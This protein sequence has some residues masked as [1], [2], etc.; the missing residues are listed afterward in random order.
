M[1]T[2]LKVRESLFSV[3]GL[4]VN[5]TLVFGVF[6]ALSCSLVLWLVVYSVNIS[7]C[8]VLFG[9]V[10]NILMKR[11]EEVNDVAAGTMMISLVPL[12]L[13]VFYTICWCFVFKLWRKVRH[14]DN[15][16]VYVCVE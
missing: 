4:I 7:G 14:R 6:Y 1:T 5:L 8:F 11:Q 13:A 2:Y 3:I 10:I 16:I 12:F 15:N 9:M